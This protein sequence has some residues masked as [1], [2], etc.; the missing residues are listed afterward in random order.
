MSKLRI[1]ANILNGLLLIVLLAAIAGFISFLNFWHVS[2]PELAGAFLS[3]AA[4]AILR[5]PHGGSLV[6]N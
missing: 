5:Q 4:G 3:I 1:V 2:L 6:I